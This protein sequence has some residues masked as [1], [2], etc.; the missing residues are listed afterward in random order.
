MRRAA[1]WIAIAVVV[2]G[3]LVGLRATLLRPQTV[4]FAV[5]VDSLPERSVRVT[6]VNL[7]DGTVEGIEHTGYPAFSVQFHPVFEA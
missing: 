5:D 6:H 1:R 3:V 7:N 2:A 4:G